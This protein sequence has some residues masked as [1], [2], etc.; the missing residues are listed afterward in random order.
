MT[1]NSDK[2]VIELLDDFVLLSFTQSQE[3]KIKQQKRKKSIQNCFIMGKLYCK[4]TNIIRLIKE[5]FAVIDAED[6]DITDSA[7]FAGGKQFYIAP[8]SVKIVFT[9]D[10]IFVMDYRAV[11]L[12]T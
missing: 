5:N 3:G 11:L 1:V 7:K 8:T 9:R 4:I 2:V 10:I 12:P 6:A